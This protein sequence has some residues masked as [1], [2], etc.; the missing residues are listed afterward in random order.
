[1]EENETVI[2]EGCRERPAAVEVEDMNGRG[3][4]VCPSCYAGDIQKFLKE[5]LQ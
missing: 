5:C 2:C 3:R 4:S 1:M